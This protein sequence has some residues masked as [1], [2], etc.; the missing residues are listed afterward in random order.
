[1]GS[2]RDLSERL[3]WRMLKVLL[4]G[5]LVF[6]VSNIL[7]IVLMGSFVLYFSSSLAWYSSAAY[8]VD[9]AAL[10][11]A[12]MVGGGLVGLMG[13]GVAW[14][15][16]TVLGL[17]ILLSLRVSLYVFGQARSLEGF[18]YSAILI[19][20]ATVLWSVLAGSAR[21]RRTQQE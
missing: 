9:R 7:L 17:L 13:P 4:F 14:Q 2:T 12:L 20:P 15:K 18:L 5:L 19:L 3:H 10:M 6:Q 21:S 11:L 1:M 8:Y 16:G